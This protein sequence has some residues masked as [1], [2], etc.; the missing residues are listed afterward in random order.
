LRISEIADI[1]ICGF[2]AE[3]A[4]PILSGFIDKHL[5][6]RQLN[7]YLQVERNQPLNAGIQE[8]APLSDA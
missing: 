4:H 7:T 5:L 8:R 1:R 2:S 6:L 3:V